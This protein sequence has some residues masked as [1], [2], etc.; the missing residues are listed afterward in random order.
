[1]HEDKG[2]KSYKIIENTSVVM[3]TIIIVM[4]F[5]RLEEHNNKNVGKYVTKSTEQNKKS[6]FA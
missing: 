3:C 1:M 5:F 4:C 6:Y 2:C